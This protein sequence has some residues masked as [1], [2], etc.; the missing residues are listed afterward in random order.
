MKWLTILI[1]A[2]MAT[3]R[4]PR[5]SAAQTMNQAA[6]SLLMQISLQLAVGWLLVGGL[7][8]LGEDLVREFR[9]QVLRRL[10]VGVV[11]ATENL[12]LGVD[13]VLT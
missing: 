1:S 2:Q 11:G 13:K 12:E 8:V 4:V 7:E 3:P 6:N 10:T 5:P 9:D